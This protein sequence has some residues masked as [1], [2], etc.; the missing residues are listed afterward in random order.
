MYP[1]LVDNPDYTRVISA[2][3]HRRL[4]ELVDDARRRGATVIEINPRDEACTAENRV[5]P[6][7]LLLDVRSG[8]AAA[9]DEVF[10]PVLPVVAYRDFE[11]AVAWINERPHPLAFYYF[12]TDRGR[13]EDVVGRV[14]AGGV[15]VNDCLLH[16]GLA[17]L[18]FGGVGPS[19]MGRYHGFDGFQ[20]FS[21]R[22]GVLIQRRWSPL[23]LLRPPYTDRTRRILRLFVRI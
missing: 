20:T 22:K 15:T 6:P 21:N 5:F 13:V 2:H 4:T 7:T 19:G 11:E 17:S 12:D 3:H 16:V 14:R 10:G 9:C 23:G 1:S 18:P 8:M